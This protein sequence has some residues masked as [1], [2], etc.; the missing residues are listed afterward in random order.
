MKSGKLVLLVAMV[1]GALMLIGSG[2]MLVVGV[3]GYNGAM[4][5]MT[6][7]K[8][9]IK[10]IY[11]DSDPFPTDDNINVY[12]GY[13]VELQKWFDEILNHLANQQIEPVQKSPSAFMST[14]G[15]KRTE[16][17]ALI[18]ENNVKMPAEF[19]LG[20]K[21][22]FEANAPLPAPRDVGRLG[23]QLFLVER[24]LTI[25]CEAKP[26]DIVRIKRELF[27]GSQVGSTSGNEE[28]TNSFISL[29]FV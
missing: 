20:F 29:F 4:S 13:D 19:D 5:E 27:E 21:K 18:K 23:Q 25:F 12:K 14:L 22:Y 11:S 3:L 6:G 10:R 2:A 28:E 17:F 26:E 15:E 1:V 24:L 8:D 9:T 16:M 7:S